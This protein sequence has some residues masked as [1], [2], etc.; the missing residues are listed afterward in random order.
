MYWKIVTN[1]FPFDRIAKSHDMLVLLRHADAITE[2]EREELEKL[3]NG[4]VN[5]HYQYIIEI[6]PNTRSIPGHYHLH[7]VVA[8]ENE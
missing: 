6:T 2:A 3:K 1:D 7:L 5:E 4:Y 8:K